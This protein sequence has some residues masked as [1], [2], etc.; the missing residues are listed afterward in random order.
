MTRRNAA[1]AALLLAAG[2]AARPAPLTAAVCDA[3]FSATA[4]A[5]NPM[6]YDPPKSYDMEEL[7]KSRAIAS[8]T[9]QVRSACKGAASDWTKASGTSLACEGTAGGL[10]CTAT[11]TPAR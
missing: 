3:P 8:W 7:A 6:N 4:H 10:D 11:G 9:A 5:A 2:L 1:R